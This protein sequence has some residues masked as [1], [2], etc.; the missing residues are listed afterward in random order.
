MSI[1]NKEIFTKGFRRVFHN[2]KL[3]LLLWGLN[4]ASALIIIMPI[5]YMLIDNLNHSLMS[6]RLALGFDSVWF[7][8]FLSLYKNFLGEMPLTFY[9]VL[10]AYILIQVF[11]SG[12]LIAVFKDHK[13]NHLVDFFYGGVKYWFRFMR[14]V[15][16]SA[17][18]FIASYIINDYAGQFIMWAFSNTEN[19]YAD[20]VLRSLRYI[21][22]VFFLV[23]IAIISD[24]SKVSLAV[25]EEYMVVREIM[26]VTLFI[27]RNFRKV[28]TIFLYVSII[29]IIGAIIY[30]LI[31]SVLPRTPYYFLVISFILQ[32][33]LIIFRLLIRMLFYSTE[34][35]IFKDINAETVD[36]TSHEKIRG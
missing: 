27:K 2:T 35:L 9:S 5:Y 8:Q 31:G 26:R 29:G 1:T 14:V 24:Y 19:V 32:Q 23:M 18:F 17:I 16:V 11:F 3:I 28:V 20:F 22:L 33:M 21:L 7:T 36:M 15:L 12:G 4:A 6:D 30:N 10:G 25:K 34:I 13:K